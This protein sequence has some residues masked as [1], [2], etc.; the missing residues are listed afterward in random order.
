M[1]TGKLLS[2]KSIATVL[3]LTLSVAAIPAL[4]QNSGVVVGGTRITHTVDDWSH[5][6]VTF[7]NPGTADQAIKNGTYD[8]WV[9][10]VNEPRYVL[11]QLKKGAPVQGPAASDVNYLYSHSHKSALNNTSKTKGA[12]TVLD[13]DW[14]M[15]LGAGTLLINTFPAKFTFDATNPGGCGDFVVYPTGSAGTAGQATI[16]A[17]TSIYGTTTCPSGPSNGGPAVSWAYNI[18]G[19]TTAL[20]PTISLDGSEVAFIG[21]SGGVAS[22]ILLKPGTGGTVAAPTAITPGTAAAYQNCSAPCATSIAFANGKTDTNSSPFYAYYGAEADT[23]YVGDDSDNL[24]EFTNVFNGTPAET[25]TGGWPVSLTTTTPGKVTSPVLDPIKD[26]VF[27]G[28]ANGVLYSVKSTG[29][30]TKLASAQIAFN[31]AGI[32]DSPIVDIATATTSN[33]YVSVGCHTAC[34][35]ASDSAVVQFSTGSSVATQTPV[36]ATL[37]TG[38]AA[39]T[40]VYGGAFDNTHESGGGTTGFM[41]ACGYGTTGTRPE[42]F[43]IPMNSF[44][45]AASSVDAA[46]TNATATCGPITEFLS[47][48]TPTTLSAALGGNRFTN[49]SVSVTSAANIAVGDYIQIDSEAMLV[50]SIAGNTLT[51]TRQSLGTTVN[52]HTSGST[53]TDDPDYLFLSV[54][55]GGNDPGCTGA[56]LYNYIV[57]NSSESLTAAQAL[58][59][60]TGI[61]AT[62]GTSGIIIDNASTAAGEEQIYYSTLG[63]QACTGN[64]TSGIGTGRCAVQTLQAAP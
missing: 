33:V 21:T 43:Q 39:A 40:V 32:V 2:L 25:T 54:T 37:G 5:H 29:T 17:Y 38:D 7:T 62:G 9:K 27:A 56:C 55:A 46:V 4:G 51:V 26:L 6:R 42:V 64:T 59:S 13:K 41:Y 12:T 1:Q 14:S 58:T 3:S 11:Q 20:S 10:V 47:V 50:G 44:T 60:V 53:V 57:G 48:K 45:G 49:T 22:L 63:S 15:D 35:G 52:T 16:V 18:S 61:T 30:P 8:K 31:T 36:V 34:S 19:V 28:D 24:H 23:I